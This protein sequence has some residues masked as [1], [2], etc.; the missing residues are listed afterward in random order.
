[1]VWSKGPGN[2]ATFLMLAAFRAA[3][4]QEAHGQL[5]DSPG[6]VDSSGLLVGATTV[7]LQAIP[8]AIASV[9]GARPVRPTSV[10]RPADASSLQ[11][12]IRPGRRPSAQP[13]ETDSMI[14]VRSAR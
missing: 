1:M 4:G 8:D 3:T 9:T 14:A 11:S 7:G 13:G 2:P 5:I 12:G 6:V 10:P